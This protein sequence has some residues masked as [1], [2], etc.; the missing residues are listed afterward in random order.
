MP[1]AVAFAP[2]QPAAR[3][4]RSLRQSLAA[5]DH[6]RQCAVLW[7]ADVMERRLYRELGYS[8]INQYAMQGLGFSRTRTGDF[9]QLVR[10][11]DKLPRV[12]AAVASGALGYTKAREIVQVA[13]PATESRWLEAAERPR[14]QLVA[15]VKRVKK[16]AAV[17]PGQAELLP[18]E[19][20]VVAPEELP[21]RYAVSLTPE[22]EAR[23]A[24]LVERLHKLGGVPSGQAE[25]LLEALA[26][27]VEV[28]EATAMP[29][30]GALSS[31]PPVQIHV[32]DHGG[33]L[34]VQTERGERTLSHADAARLRCDAAISRPGRRNTT[35]IPPATRRAVLARDRHQCQ[36]PGCGR[37]RFLEVHHVTPRSR[38]GTNDQANLTTL[39]SACHRLLHALPSSSSGEPSAAPTAGKT[40]RKASP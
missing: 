14:A 30:R 24:A 15:E 22:Q 8:S 29:P 26:A 12:K 11:L 39:C 13:T 33:R 7:F 38:G 2:G 37:T 17:A 19:P 28:Q 36:S 25:L 21:V 16:A 27:L 31:R 32:H 40:S 35:T 1:T 18:A 6:A 20:T 34:T 10:R 4:H 23:R 3:V 5:M 9:I